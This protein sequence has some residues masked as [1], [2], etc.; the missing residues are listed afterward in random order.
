LGAVFER[1]VNELLSRAC[2]GTKAK[3]LAHP[4]SVDDPSV[5]ICDGLLATADSVVLIEYKSS[6]FRA[7]RKYSGNT[8]QLL[9]EIERKLVRNKDKGS[10]KG[11]QQLAAAVEL[12]FKDSNAQEILPDIAWTDIKTIHLCLVTLDSIGETIGM[13]ALLNT[14]LCEGLDRSRFPNIDI[15]PLCCLDI[16]S[17]ERVTGYFKS[18]TLPDIFGRWLRL[19]ADLVASLSMV[20]L[21]KPEQNPWLRSEWEDIFRHIVMLLFPNADPEEVIAG[22]RRGA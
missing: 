2:S 19:S 3:F 17:L 15:R 14:H 21:G 1:Y 8:T 4:R 20:Q 13:S 16:A 10:K 22:A 11:V 9:E 12:L 6:M 5:Q 7:D 18:M